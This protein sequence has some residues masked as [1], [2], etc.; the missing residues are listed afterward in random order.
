MTVLKF[1]GRIVTMKKSDYLEA[2][3]V[4]LNLTNTPADEVLRLMDTM[5][6]KRSLGYHTK[7]NVWGYNIHSRKD[8]PEP[9]NSLW[10]SPAKLGV[11]E[12]KV[13]GISKTNPIYG[14]HFLQH[15]GFLSHIGGIGV[16]KPKEG[17]WLAHDPGA[18]LIL[19]RSGLHS[20]TRLLD[21]LK[22]ANSLELCRVA[23]AGD[24]VLG[25]NK[26][27][28]TKR[29][30]VYKV[31]PS[32]FDRVLTET[33]LGLIRSNEVTGKLDVH[34]RDRLAV[35]CYKLSRALARNPAVSFTAEEK[36]TTPEW[37]IPEEHIYDTLFDEEV[38]PKDNSLVASM[39]GFWGQEKPYTGASEYIR[40][41][42]RML[43]SL[44]F[45][46]MDHGFPPH[47]LRLALLTNAGSIAETGTD[48]PHLY[49]PSPAVILDTVSVLF[50]LALDR[51]VLIGHRNDVEKEKLRLMANR[52]PAA[53]T[54]S[55][56]I[57]KINNDIPNCVI[58]GSYLHVESS[59]VINVETG[60]YTCLDS[61]CWKTPGFS[62]NVTESIVR[63]RM[64]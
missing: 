16:E 7:H 28:A 33:I 41:L 49:V 27:V 64:I 55:E 38:G 12:D 56:E 24:V 26:L 9:P 57:N 17:E 44:V 23:S 3:V 4:S 48:N 13:F 45:V 11:T 32:V 43:I 31:L 47:L 37:G 40:L 58:C 60:S 36:Y 14:W 15:D 2:L 5:Q 61:E 25:G 34:N 1:G 30:I 39:C 42:N 22:Y 8:I 6:E 35:L 54:F 59:R 63:H 18:P 19:C 62:V 53:R 29:K 21:A 20:S 46:F 10:P 50:E 51:Y 52:L